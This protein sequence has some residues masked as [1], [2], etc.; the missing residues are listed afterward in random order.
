MPEEAAV[1]AF[2]LCVGGLIETV[3]FALTLDAE[4]VLDLE[5]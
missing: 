1:A 3:F 4:D 5:G 2:E